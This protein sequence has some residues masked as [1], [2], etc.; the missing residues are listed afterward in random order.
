[1]FSSGYSQNS[2][3]LM[4]TDIHK[5]TDTEQPPAKPGDITFLSILHS[6]FASFIGIQNNKNRQRDFE[7][8]KFWHFFAAGLIFVA[9][10]LLVIW[11]A[12]QYLIATT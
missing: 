12:V 6:V 8:G 7:S 2:L 9:I 4:T 11:L 3:N 10:F 5:H 1:M